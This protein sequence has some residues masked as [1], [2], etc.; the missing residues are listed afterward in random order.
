MLTVD[1]DLGS[2]HKGTNIVGRKLAK[3][4]GYVYII[5]PPLVFVVAIAATNQ[6]QL[7]WDNKIQYYSCHNSVP[8]LLDTVTQLLVAISN[9]SESSHHLSQLIKHFTMMT[10]YSNDFI[11]DKLTRLIL[12][13][14]F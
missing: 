13:V 5:T 6:Q 9:G 1:T 2:I 11:R 12:T 7:S 10:S 8:H 14:V 3:I 4:S